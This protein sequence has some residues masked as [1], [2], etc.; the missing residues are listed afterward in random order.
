MFVLRKLYFK[1]TSISWL[2]LTT[3]TVGLILLSTIILPLIEPYTFSSNMDSFWFTMTTMLTV[4]YGDLSP[5][6]TLGR[7]YTIIFL[8]VIGIGLFATFIGKA[9]ESLTIYRKLKE[10]G[11]LMFEGENH[12]VI[13][14]WSHKAEIAIKNILS[15]DK[16][17]EIVVIDTNE[18]AL[19]IHE[20]I[21][22]VRGYA[23]NNGTLEQ[24][25]IQ[26]AKAILIFA[27]DRVS[28]QVLTDG[29]SLMIACAV[30]RIAP[31]VRTIVEVER[32][33]HI[34]NFS[35]I[36]IDKFLLSDGTIAQLAVDS[37]E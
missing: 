4:G 8:Y 33:E 31:H 30:E 17:V 3:F 18:K 6:S 22:Y 5:S 32:E 10:K 36:N 35:H 37:I 16:K 26:K 14:D 29:K 9:M 20:R 25:N 13:I 2:V 27:D 23:T 34:E 19:E 12:I 7:I 15:K 21:H 28:D 24:A 1:M 11:D